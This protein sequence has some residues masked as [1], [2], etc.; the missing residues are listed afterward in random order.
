MLT[1]S[2]LL[3]KLEALDNPEMVD[4]MHHHWSRFKTVHPLQRNFV[5]L[6]EKWI[7]R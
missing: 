2:Q 3:I 4:M 7:R 6:W 5:A 1:R